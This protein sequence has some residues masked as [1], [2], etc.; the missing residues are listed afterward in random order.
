MSPKVSIST[1]LKVLI[2]KFVQS[3]VDDHNEKDSTEGLKSNMFDA[4][5]SEIYC[6]NGYN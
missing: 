2:A 5:N 4:G 1:I 3:I 6:M